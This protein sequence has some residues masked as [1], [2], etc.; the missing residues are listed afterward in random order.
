MQ[1]LPNGYKVGSPGALVAIVC[2][3]L[4]WVLQSCG[5]APAQEYSGWQLALG[6]AAAGEK[7]N[8]NFFVF[9]ILIFAIAVLALAVMAMRRGYATL[10]DGISLVGLGGLVLLFLYQQFGTPV[11]EGSTR[12]ILYGLWGEVIG[13]VLVV[14]GG[15][16][17]FVDSRKPHT[18][19]TGGVRSA[20]DD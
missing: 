8:G 12:E 11:P 7:Y 16:L 10:G 20:G 3:F 4:P 14:L 6:S 19:M 1:K 15:V 5:S 9:L 13:W 17:N 18:T 2:F